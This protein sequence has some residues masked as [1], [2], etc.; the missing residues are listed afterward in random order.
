VAVDGASGS[1]TLFLMDVTDHC[2]RV[3]FWKR[4]SVRERALHME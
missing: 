2:R 3:L 4:G 1:P